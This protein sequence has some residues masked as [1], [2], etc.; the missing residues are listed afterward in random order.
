ME[1]ESQKSSQTETEKIQNA[2]RRV[3]VY[4][5]D[6]SSQWED[7]GTGHV[8]CVFV[9]VSGYYHQHIYKLLSTWSNSLQI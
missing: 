6:S 2:K 3:K 8:D 5:L 4:Q 1:S 9:E 7:K